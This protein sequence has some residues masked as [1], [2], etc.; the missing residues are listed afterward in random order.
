[1]GAEG[2]EA[3]DID[4]NRVERSVPGDLGNPDRARAILDR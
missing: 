2:I 3:A 1:M 4:R